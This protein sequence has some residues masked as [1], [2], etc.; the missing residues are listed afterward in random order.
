MD[1]PSLCTTLLSLDPPWNSTHCLSGQTVAMYHPLI[2]GSSLKYY[3][4]VKWT[5]VTMY[6]PL[7]L[8]SSLK[9][10]PL[11]KWTY[12]LYVP[13]SHPW[14][15]P[16]ILP[17]V[18]VDRPLLC[19]TLSSLDPPWNSTHCL[20]GQTVTMYH[21]VIIGSSLKFYPLF[22]WTDRRYVPP[23]HSWILPEILPFG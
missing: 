13:P 1:R 8:R 14:I 17:I 12:W 21:P 5:D 20:S 2:L 9:Y 4:L 16:E 15:L 23:S 11:F 22:K 7:N 6:H 3:P 18:L 10:Y 19:T